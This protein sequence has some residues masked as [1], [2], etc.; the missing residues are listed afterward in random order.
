MAMFTFEYFTIQMDL[1][2]ID[3]EFAYTYY[4]NN[5]EF[6]VLRQ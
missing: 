1:N 5:I 2:L 4:S 6:L 3:I